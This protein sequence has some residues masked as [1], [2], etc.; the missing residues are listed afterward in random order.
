VSGTLGNCD[1]DLDLDLVIDCLTL[2]GL[3]T[4]VATLELQTKQMVGERQGAWEAH[5]ANSE[6]M[7]R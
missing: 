3:T 6:I 5:Y 4:G 7:L 2:Q 1:L